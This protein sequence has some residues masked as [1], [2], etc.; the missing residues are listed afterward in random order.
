M[1]DNQLKEDLIFLLSFAPARS[2]RDVAK[3]LA[4]MFYVTGSY[5]GDLEIA[6]RVEDILVRHGIDLS[7]LDEDED[8]EEEN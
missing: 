7:K 1:S 2:T 3:G 5:K 4:P 6:K 8:L